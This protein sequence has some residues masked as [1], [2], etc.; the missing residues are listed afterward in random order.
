[1]RRQVKSIIILL[2]LGITGLSQQSKALPIGSSL[3]EQN[4][5]HW[6]SPIWSQNISYSDMG[7]RLSNPS[8][9]YCGLRIAT[10]YEVIDMLRSYPLIHP[11]F[12]NSSDSFTDSF[13]P[14]KLDNSRTFGP[15]YGAM[16]AFFNEFGWIE[17]GVWPN[18]ARGIAGYSWDNVAGRIMVT[19]V[20]EHDI[21][22]GLFTPDSY[23]LYIATYDTSVMG[24]YPSYGTWLVQPAPIPE[25]ETLYLI[26]AGLALLAFWRHRISS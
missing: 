22:G 12:P 9:V 23:E 3:V 10:A 24:M 16:D 2:F 1:M 18:Y 4:G 13:M 19:D 21:Y 15:A 26:A 6:L 7:L 25:P 14:G 17:R 5:L 20:S 11:A 8:S